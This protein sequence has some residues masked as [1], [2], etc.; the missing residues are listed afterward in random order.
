MRNTVFPSASSSIPEIP[1]AE[2]YAGS[3]SGSLLVAFSVTS[4]ISASPVAR[5]SRMFRFSW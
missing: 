5:E 3:T 2:K 4:L 1:R